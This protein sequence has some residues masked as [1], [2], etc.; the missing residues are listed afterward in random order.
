MTSTGSAGPLTGAIP[1]SGL[2]VFE[3]CPRAPIY[4]NVE[5]FNART[6]DFLSRHSGAG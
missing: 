1:P 6:M 4:E 2:M 5:D 3:D